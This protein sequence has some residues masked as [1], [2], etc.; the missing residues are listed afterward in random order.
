MIPEQE[1]CVTLIKLEPEYE[2]KDG[3]VYGIY[4][5]RVVYLNACGIDDCKDKIKSSGY[6]VDYKIKEKEGIKKAGYFAE[7]IWRYYQ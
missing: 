7:L 6:L 3:K 4:E 2:H 5:I 1:Y